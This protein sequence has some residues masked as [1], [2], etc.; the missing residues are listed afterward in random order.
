MDILEIIVAVVTTV[1][2]SYGLAVSARRL[3]LHRHPLVLC[4]RRRRPGSFSH[5]ITQLT[6]ELSYCC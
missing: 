5:A 6:W 4:L 3:V 1:P 2:L